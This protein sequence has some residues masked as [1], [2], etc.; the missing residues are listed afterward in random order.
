MGVQAWR[1][2]IFRIKIGKTRIFP[3]ITGSIMVSIWFCYEKRHQSVAKNASACGRFKCLTISWQTC[4][5][6]QKRFSFLLWRRRTKVAM[7]EDAALLYYFRLQLENNLSDDDQLGGMSSANVSDD[8]ADGNVRAQL[9]AEPVAAA[10]HDTVPAGV[11]IPGEDL[12]PALDVNA[13]LQPV[14]GHV[15]RGRAR[16]CGR[17]GR[18]GRGAAEVVTG[19]RRGRGRGVGRG[20]GAQAV[21][22]TSCWSSARLEC[23]AETSCWSSAWLECRAETSCWSS[24]WLECRAETSCWSS[25]WLE[26]R[27]RRCVRSTPAFGPERLQVPKVPVFITRKCRATIWVRYFQSLLYRL[28]A[29]HTCWCNQWICLAQH[30]RLSI[31]GWQVWGMEADGCP[32]D[33]DKCAFYK[34]QRKSKEYWNAP[35]YDYLEI[36]AVN[37]YI[38]FEEYRRAH[39]GA[40]VRTVTYN[41]SEFRV[42]L[43]RQLADIAIDAPVPL[44]KPMGAVL[45]HRVLETL[46]S[47]FSHTFLAGVNLLHPNDECTRFAPVPWFPNDEFTCSENFSRRCA[48]GGV[49]IASHTAQNSWSWRLQLVMYLATKW[50]VICRCV[51]LWRV[52]ANARRIFLFCFYL[53]T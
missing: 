47:H 38:L 36:T 24:A 11:D 5:L 20:A 30:S 8:E 19:C 7:D 33:Q 39:L 10:L 52:P 22:E 13:P 14:A 1:E 37:C 40:I 53:V 42:H 41:H 21:A 15:V 23:R 51:A 3:V 45:E 16:G 12:P 27:G 2:L 43:I 17:G 34:V 29:C 49:Y 28:C 50:S 4:N 9:E 35:C 31:P 6:L 18:H 48:S 44:Y 32:W 46:K 25:A 26:C